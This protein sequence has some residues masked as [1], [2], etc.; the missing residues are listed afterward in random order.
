MLKNK[1]LNCIY[2]VLYAIP[3]DTC[4]I[5]YLLNKVLTLYCSKKYIKGFNF[6]LLRKCDTIR[7]M[8]AHLL[9]RLASLIKCE[10]EL[11]KKISQEL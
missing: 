1:N 4:N 9:K 11:L 8:V 2:L 5:L 3:S 7:S 6:L 10:N